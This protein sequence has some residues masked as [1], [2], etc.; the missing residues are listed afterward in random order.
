MTNSTFF[1][2]CRLSRLAPAAL[3]ALVLSAPGGQAQVSDAVLSTLGAPDRIETQFGTLDFKDGVPT[4]E[5]A[6]KTYDMLDFAQALNVYNN[7]FRG[8]SA[9]AIA[10]GLESIGAKDNDVAIFSDLMDASSLFLT[11]NADTVY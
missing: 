5:T 6:Q 3:G 9:Y 7:S 11:A 2:A 1:T 4:A 8:A 10:A